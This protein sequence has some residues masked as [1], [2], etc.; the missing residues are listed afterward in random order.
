MITTE[1]A[2]RLVNLWGKESCSGKLP[3]DKRRIL[4]VYAGFIIGSHAQLPTTEVT[5]PVNY[6][7]SQHEAASR[8]MFDQINNFTFI[9]TMLAVEVSRNVYLTRYKMVF[10]PVEA[11]RVCLH[12]MDGTL[13]T[14]QP[15]AKEIITSIDKE[16]FDKLDYING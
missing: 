14:L 13:S 15:K 2:I 12:T 5:D 6:Y 8:S 1:K 3:H 10:N 16:L 7:V 9:D 4:G 11:M